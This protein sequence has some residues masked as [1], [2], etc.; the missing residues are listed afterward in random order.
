MTTETPSGSL[1][2]S[3]VDMHQKVHYF[4]HRY[5]M[6]NKK[7]YSS[8]Y[9]L[10]LSVNSFDKVTTSS[11]ETFA[12]ILTK[13]KGTILIF[14]EKDGFSEFPDFNIFGKRAINKPF[15]YN[16]STTVLLRIK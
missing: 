1:H 4:C 7:Y 16:A 6:K 2:P 9:T 15:F 3:S 10:P 13:E 14:T 8:E 5:D 11:N 12:I